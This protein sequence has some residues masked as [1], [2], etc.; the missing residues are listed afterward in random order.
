LWAVLGNHDI[1]SDT[2]RIVHALTN[3]GIPVLRNQS[4]AIEKDGARFWLSGIDDALDGAPSLDASL[5]GVPSDEATI[6]LA[7]EPD[8]ADFAAHYPI[9]LQ[10]SGHSHGGQ[11][12]LPFLRPLYLPDLAKKYIA[13]L[14]QVDGLTLY[15]NRGIGTVGLPVRFNCPPEITLVTVR[16]AA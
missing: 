14:F 12:K 11:V 5:R 15:T 7:H 10:L 6:L 4:V 1:G 16:G 2:E 8:Y 13:G 3:A 9:D